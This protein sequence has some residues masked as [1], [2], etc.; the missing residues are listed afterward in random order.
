MVLPPGLSGRIVA[1]MQT[2]PPAGSPFIITV[3][4]GRIWWVLAVRFD[5]VTSAAATTRHAVIGS[6]LRNLRNAV[7]ALFPA[8]QGASA[9]ITYFATYL[10]PTTAPAGSPFIGTTLPYLV[11]YPGENIEIRVFN[12]NAADQ[13]TNILLAYVEYVL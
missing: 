8:T 12:M 2:P 4:A 6:Y 10:G 9:S 11:V 1:N 3:P 7:I 5:L 13:I